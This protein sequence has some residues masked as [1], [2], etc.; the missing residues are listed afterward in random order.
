MY[1]KPSVCVDYA[2]AC[3]KHIT[4]KNQEFASGNAPLFTL[5]LREK[6]GQLHT[7]SA[8]DAK[9]VTL[10]EQGAVYSGFSQNIK[11]TVSCQSEEDHT[12]WGFSAENGNDMAIKAYRVFY[13]AAV[14]LGAY[15]P[16]SAVWSLADIFNALMIVPNLWALLALSDEVIKETRVQKK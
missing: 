9:T 8:Q 3:I 5:Q 12:T 2:S 11:I 13:I 16:L 1:V 6:N 15:L 14:G 7:V 10:T 4:N